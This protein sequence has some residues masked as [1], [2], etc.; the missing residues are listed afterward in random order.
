MNL[1]T[2]PEG[3]T[4]EFKRDLSSP[5]PILK[6][7]IAFANTAGSRLITGVRRI[8]DQTK[9]LELPEPEIEEIG[10]RL[11]F[12]IF[13]ALPHIV[14]NQ[15][16][17]TQ[18]ELKERAQSGARF[19]AQSEQI[20]KALSKSDLS[21]TELMLELGLETKTGAFKRTIKALLESGIIEYTIPE[22]PSSRLQKYRLKQKK[23]AN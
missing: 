6:T 8:F 4:L 14:T 10:M 20:L 5:I 3:K 1:I 16:S 19:G 7:L 9:Q 13:L 2:Q 15:I 11:R 23:N 18:S 21:A 12:T 22:K 17:Q